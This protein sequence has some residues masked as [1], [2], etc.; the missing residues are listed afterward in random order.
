MFRRSFAPV[1]SL[2]ILLLVAPSAG[3]QTADELVAKN[4]AAKGGLERLKAVH[5]LRQTSDITIQGMAAKLTIYSKRPNL[6]RQE[7]AFGADTIISVFDGQTPWMV[8]PMSGSTQATVIT[9]PQADM[10]RIDASF[11]GP[12]IDYKAR[13]LRV[14]LIG[15]ENVD[16]TA[17]HHLKVT[18]G[19]SLEKHI[20]LDASTSLEVKIASETP[21]GMVEQRFSDYREVGGLTVPYSITLL[22]GGAVTAQIKLLTVDLNAEID[23]ALFRIPR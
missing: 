4:I 16:G 5:S 22:T 13:G 8:N 12:L 6:T 9:G 11:D 19:D 1:L 21:N 20:Y 15:A 23:D 3:A 10:I 17:V 2:A 14:E 18:G 7:I